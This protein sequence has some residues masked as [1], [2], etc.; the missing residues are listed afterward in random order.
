MASIRCNYVNKAVV[1]SLLTFLGLMPVPPP[2][3]KI[4][5]TSAQAEAMP[6]LLMTAEECATGRFG[7]RAVGGSLIYLHEIRKPQVPESWC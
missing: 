2:L 7:K 6:Q 5:S 1:I 4:N 3:S